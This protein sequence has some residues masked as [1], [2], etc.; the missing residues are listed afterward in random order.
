MRTLDATGVETASPVGRLLKHWRAKRRMSQLDLAVDADIS[1][2]HLSFVETGRARPS[3]D[4]VARLGRAL[5]VPLRD[6]N[7]LLTAAGYAPSFRESR[8]DDPELAE[9]RGALQHMLDAHEPYGAIVVDRNWD[10]LMLNQGAIRLIGFFLPTA[11]LQAHGPLNA[12]RLLL[13][14]QG[15]KPY[16]VNWQEIAEHHLQRM[17][18]EAAAQGEPETTVLAETL[19][20]PGLPARLRVPDY[21]APRPPLLTMRLRKGDIEICLFSTIAT[22]GT[23][24]DVTLQELRIEFFYPGD[25]PTA[26]FLRGL[27]N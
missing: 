5:D 17:H 20:L 4:M 26:A 10:I 14:E 8:L 2:R 11:A 1:T 19:S 23:P 21:S 15:L 22:F 16:L 12:S 27:S 7:A 3:R 13:S 24:Q 9:A 18:R 25:E 6:A